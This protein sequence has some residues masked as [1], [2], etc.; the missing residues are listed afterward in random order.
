MAKIVQLKQKLRPPK[1]NYPKDAVTDYALEVLEGG[2]V[3]GLPVRLACWRHLNDLAT[4]EADGYYWDF[5][6]A[7][8][9]FDFCKEMLVVKP[10][11]DQQITRGVQALPFELF[12]W[13]VF[14]TGSVYGWSRAVENP[15]GT[16]GF[17]R[18]FWDVFILTA[19]GSGKTPILAAMSLFGLLCDGE[20]QPEIYV[21]ALNS[22]Q[23]GIAFK[24][25]TDMLEANPALQAVTHRYGGIKP[26]DIFNLDRTGY[27]KRLPGTV[28]SQ[29]KGLAGFRPS[30]VMIDEL[31]EHRTADMLVALRDGFKNRRQPLTVITTNS[32]NDPKSPCGVEYHRA[33][34]VL[35]KEVKDN[36][37]FAYVAQLDEGDDPYADTECWVKPNPALPSHP[38]FEYLERKVELSRYTPSL[39]AETLRVNFSAWIRQ[40]QPWIDPEIW[41]ALQVDSLTP[42]RERKKWPCYLALDLAA[43]TDFTAGIAVWV[44][45]K[46]QKFEAE[47]FIWTPEATLAERAKNDNADYLLWKE[48]GDLITTP[49]IFL[50]YT[51]LAEWLKQFARNNNLQGV[52]YDQRFID[53]LTQRMEELGVRLTSDPKLPGLLMIQHYQGKFMP[54]KQATPKFKQNKEHVEVPVL[55]MPISINVTEELLVNQGIKIKRNQALT[56]AML[57][58]ELEP[59]TMGNRAFDKA[60]SGARIDPAVALTMAC[61]YALAPETKFIERKFTKK[62]IELF[63]QLNKIDE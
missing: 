18:R 40:L 22:R 29:G 38:G 17:P 31:H 58:V 59:D 39:K 3:A 30:M 61:G 35:R 9:F 28:G 11:P 49:G 63:D 14:T 50:N 21:A 24:D 20:L 5:S 25:I 41:E 27:I 1:F 7:Q 37:L 60:E 15:Y 44:P 43:T 55:N 16:D 13:Q 10:D 4:A 56:A 52:A 34:R 6:K 2:I 53:F 54:R 26:T 62:D 12:G 46:K 48:Q 23:S 51:K 8:F 19:K 36:K 57:G 45:P 47:A 32:G 42:K 33:M